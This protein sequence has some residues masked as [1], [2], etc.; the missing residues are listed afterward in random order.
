MSVNVGNSTGTSEEV[1]DYYAR[2]W[3]KIANCY[4]VDS[5]GLPIDPAW[6][7]RRQYKDFLMQHKPATVLDV[8]CG[9][10]WTVLDALE[11]GLDAQGI[12]PVTEL[13]AHGSELL[14][15]KGHDGSRITKNDLASLSSYPSNSFDC[16]SLLSVLPHVP[17]EKWGS[18]HQ[19]IARVLRPGG[20]LIAAYRNELFDLYTFNSLTLEFYD[21]SLWDCSPCDTLQTDENISRLKGL[22]TKPDLPGPYFTAA[23]DKS[24]GNLKRVKSNPLTMPLYLNQFGLLVENTKFYHY[25]CVPP[26]LADQTDNYREINHQMELTMSDDWRGN[27]MAAIFMVE[28]V[29]E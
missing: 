23:T 28:A 2:N 16:I 24:F 1:L 18:V 14:Q 17:Q 26:L 7:R 19:E 6:Y 20:R 8:G 27:F 22:I 5:D 9:G 25:H 11:L 3:E 10:G 13:Q 21:Q 4:D 15:S 29:L 12:E